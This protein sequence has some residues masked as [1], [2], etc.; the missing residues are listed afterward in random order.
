ME[1][2]YFQG[3]IFRGELLVF[4]GSVAVKATRFEA[5]RRSYTE[6]KVPLGLRGG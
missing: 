3:S 2:P 5:W 1:S 6:E 4:P